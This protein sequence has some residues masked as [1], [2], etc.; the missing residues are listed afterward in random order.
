[1]PIF[2]THGHAER[3]H[4]HAPAPAEDMPSRAT[5]PAGPHPGTCPIFTPKA[6]QNGFMSKPWPQRR[7]C[8]LAARTRPAPT[9]GHAHS[10]HLRPRTTGPCPRPGPTGGHA[11]WCHKSRP[12]P[13]RDM[14]ILHT[15][16][17]AERVHAHAPARPEDMPSGATNPGRTHRGTCPIFTPKAAHNG[18]MP[19]PRL[20]RRTCPLVPATKAQP[21]PPVYASDWWAMVAVARRCASGGTSCTISSRKR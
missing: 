13:P 10:S 3:V 2:R 16:G 5:N 4:A 7:T 6:A 15:Q 20:Q 17:H 8:P 21:R 18:S 9:T 1:M 19:T 14:L 11:Q 12:D